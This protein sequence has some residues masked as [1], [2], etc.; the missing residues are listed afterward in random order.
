[1]KAMNLSKFAAVLLAGTGLAA[2]STAQA[3]AAGAIVDA[4]AEVATPLTISNTTGLSFGRLGPTGIAGS[5]TLSTSGTRTASNVD[6]LP[7]GTVSAAAFDISGEPNEAYTIT[8][9]ASAT[10]S[11]GGNNMTVDTFTHDAGGSPALDG[12]G[13]DSFNVGADVAVGGSQPGGAYTGTFSV[14]VDYQ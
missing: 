13:N 12:S 10:I 7:G 11:S 6:L 9:P 4:D 1:M 5:V 8:F 2:L 3:F 14:T